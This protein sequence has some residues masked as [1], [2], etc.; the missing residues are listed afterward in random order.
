MR[1]AVFLAEQ[2]GGD[3]EHH[4]FDRKRTC[5]SSQTVFPIKPHCEPG[6]FRISNADGFT[7]YGGIIAHMLEPAI[8]NL[9]D[10]K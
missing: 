4:P 7:R 1:I 5:E 3:F 2:A 9:R 6:Q 10:Q 8:R